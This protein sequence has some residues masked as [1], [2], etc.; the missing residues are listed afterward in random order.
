MKKRTLSRA[1]RWRSDEWVAIRRLAR[2]MVMAP[3]STIRFVVL[4]Y[5]EEKKAALRAAEESNREPAQRLE[6]GAS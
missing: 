2:E 6:H 1:I 4:K 5:I 3:S